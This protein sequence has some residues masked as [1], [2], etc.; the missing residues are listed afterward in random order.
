MDPTHFR[1]KEHHYKQLHD[2][3]FFGTKLEKNFDVNFFLFI[4]E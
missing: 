1:F 4:F 2:Y 3:I